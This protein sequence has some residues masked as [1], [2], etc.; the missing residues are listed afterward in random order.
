M[1]STKSHSSSFSTYP[2]S[3]TLT[4]PSSSSFL[5]P[6][7]S[8]LTSSFSP[9]LSPLLSSSTT[10]PLSLS[11]ENDFNFRFQKL[12]VDIDHL[13]A[14]KASFAHIPFQNAVNRV[15]NGSLIIGELCKIFQVKFCCFFR[16]F[17][18]LL[19]S[20]SF[21]LCFYVFVFY[22]SIWITLLYSI[23]FC[24]ISFLGSR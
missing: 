17:F 9:S 8:T 18:L 12:S 10:D 24:P 19:I 16:S 15:D 7:S 6:T 23:C 21:F 13:L 22:F 4:S 3:N 20:S 11:S 14:N 2:P 1:K 5:S